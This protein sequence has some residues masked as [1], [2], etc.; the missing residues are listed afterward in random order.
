MNKRESKTKTFT[1]YLALS[2]GTLLVSFA[3]KQ[4]LIPCRIVTGSISGLSLI[5]QRLNPLNSS[6]IVLVLNL[7]CLAIGAL[8]LGKKFGVRC[9]Y[10]SLLQPLMMA[11]IPQTDSLI[12]SYTVLNIVFF[13]ISLTLGQCI[14]LRADA[15]SGGLDTIAEVLAKTFHCSSGTTV[16][17]IGLIVSVLT[18]G[19]YDLKTA[20]IGAAVTTA[21]GA[22]ID[23]VSS[24]LK[25]IH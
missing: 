3:V 17:L 23:G 21:N 2:L 20:V 11:L 14:L 19:F 4:Y 10:V 6:L 25:G 18:L 1:D 16:A 22:M 13:L 9:V 15:S 5:V 7:V 24:L 12:S 8:L